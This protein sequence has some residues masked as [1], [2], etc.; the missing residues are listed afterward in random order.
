MKK[1]F[2]S[3]MFIISVC[4]TIIAQNNMMQM[5][6][7]KILIGQG[8][9]NDVPA[10]DRML[11]QNLT[12]AQTTIRILNK[13]ATTSFAP[14]LAVSKDFGTSGTNSAI[15]GTV[16][17]TT[18]VS[19][20]GA[21]GLYISA[22]NGMSGYNSAIFAFLRGSNDGSAIWAASD[23]YASPF[24]TGGKFAGYFMGR[25]YISERLGIGQTS[26]SYTLDVSGTIRCTSLTQTSDLRA[27]TNIADLGSK[28]QQV[29]QL[30]AV[31]YN[32]LDDEVQLRSGQAKA[33]A[34]TGKTVTDMRRYLA[35][36]EKKDKDREHI[37]FIAQ[38]FKTVFP[39]LVYE[40]EKGV[41]SIDYLSLIPIL[42]ETIQELNKRL[43]A[44][45][46]KQPGIVKEIK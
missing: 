16:Y 9:I 10:G 19:T 1:V 11:I 18:P 28:I 4:F 23:Q 29:R 3:T 7:S 40:D 27:K 33:V 12:E 20:L 37:G 26:P 43:E 5:N 31:K 22:G 2:L 35:L 36:E 25:T 14:T 13:V 39:E 21:Y 8:S 46:N 38:E 45:E 32:L 30:R 6:N 24:I 44:V 17:N 42:V 34:D 41:L 15:W